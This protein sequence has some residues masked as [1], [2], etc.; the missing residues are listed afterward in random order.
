M[1]KSAS[2][3]NHKQKKD[4][5][6]KTSFLK[7][8]KKSSLSFLAMA[9]LLLGIIGLV[10][11]FQVLVTPAMIASLFQGNPLLDTLIGT[12]TGSVAAG[13]PIVSYLIGGELLEQGISLYAV[14]A[15]ILSWVTLG[16]IQLP[17][18]IEIFGGRFTLYRNI[19]SFIFCMFIA[20]L[21]A[22]TMQVIS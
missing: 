21:T 2:Q 18:E 13:N 3:Q 5:R 22:I 16:L 11:L 17:A 19:L 14:S 6:K 4:S 10:G 20:G 15:F 7:V 1:K 12:L 8:L 9:P